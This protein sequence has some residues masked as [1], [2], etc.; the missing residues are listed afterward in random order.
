MKKLKNIILTLFVVILASF[1]FS[2]C[3]FFVL[4]NGRSGVVYAVYQM[5][6]SEDYNVLLQRKEATKDRM[7]NYLISLGFTQN[8]IAIEGEDRLRVEVATDGD[9]YAVKRLLKD[10]GEPSDFSIRLD[11]IYGEDIGITGRNITALRGYFDSVFETYFVRIFLDSV[12]TTRFANATL[13]KNF[14]RLISFVSITGG[15]EQEISRPRIQTHITNGRIIISGFESEIEMNR[16]IN[17]IISGQ[18][19]TRLTLI[20]TGAR[21]GRER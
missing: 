8:T 15:I 20:E 14:E 10:M 9:Q 18:F 16:F 17:Q 6:V 11:S 5:N 7:K 12:G 19:E 21:G 4:Q 1:S 2:A 3:D 13:P